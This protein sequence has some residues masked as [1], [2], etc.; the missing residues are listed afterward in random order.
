[1]ADAKVV[2][3]PGDPN[4]KLMLFNGGNTTMQTYPMQLELEL[5]RS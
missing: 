5:F 4:I 2:A 1:M 3:S